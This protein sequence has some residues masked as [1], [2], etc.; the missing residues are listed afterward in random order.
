[1]KKVLLVSVLGLFLFSCGKSACDCLKESTR[2]AE[3][4]IA[5]KGD[6]AKTA[7]IAKEAAENA[8]DCKD[9]TEED[10]KDCK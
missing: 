6:P 3:E 9:Y 5:A 4:A 1:M 10:S 7:E 2:L 8:E